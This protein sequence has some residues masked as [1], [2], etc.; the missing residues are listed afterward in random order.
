MTTSENIV[1]I[2]TK[3]RRI[4]EDEKAFLQNVKNEKDNLFEEIKLLKN[5][6][7]E[8]WLFENILCQFFVDFV[9]I[10]DNYT[11]NNR[12]SKLS[13]LENKLDRKIKAECKHEYIE[14]DV[15]IDLDR[16]VRI[17]YCKKCMCTF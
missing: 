6:H 4:I 16:S 17:T 9:K 11:I 1:H 3:M 7:A 8:K 15:D 10:N 12:L 13:A 14:D 2:L 5:S